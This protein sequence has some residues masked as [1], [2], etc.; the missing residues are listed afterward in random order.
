MLFAVA[1]AVMGVQL[2]MKSVP[3][4]EEFAKLRIM[5]GLVASVYLVVAV[6]AAIEFTYW[7]KYDFEAAAFL[8]L[9][10]TAYQFVLCA[11]TII[12]CFNPAFTTRR[13]IAQ[14]VGITSLW[15][16]PLGIF[17]YLN[18]SWAIYA[19]FA[20]YILQI[21]LG[22]TFLYRKYREGAALIKA[23]D[24]EH[25]I[26]LHWLH[27]GTW[28]MF[29][30]AMLMVVVSLLPPIVHNVFTL[31]IAIGYLL[32]ATRFSAFADRLY[33]EYFPI[34]TDAGLTDSKPE[35]TESYR[36]RKE[37][38]SKAID[39]WVAKKGFCS[40][41]P[42]RD[43]VAEKIGLSKE[44]MQWYFSVCLKTEFRSW[45]V[46]LRIGEAQEIL[47][48]NPSAP[49]NELA[50]TLGFTS[51]ANFFAHFK[52]ITGETTQEFIANRTAGKTQG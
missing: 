24:T 30:Y 46:K 38:C 43:S 2:M 26:N 41:D 35:E 18:Y 6:F 5:K 7:D 31:C 9:S 20:V 45:R 13:R 11:A 40:P 22:I 48:S 51:K 17:N 16:V 42:D 23:T 27:I 4:A 1:L 19:V 34:L 10:C 32:F 50:R 33:Q 8:N 25:K 12:T 36:Q 14:W 39:E 49:V 44:D 29:S 37:Y 21:T 3:Q 15:V 52:R 28:Y 47:T